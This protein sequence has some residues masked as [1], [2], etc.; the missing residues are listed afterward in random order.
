MIK[1]IE[2]AH[3]FNS[4]MIGM[5]LFDGSMPSEKYLYLRHG[6]NQL[7]YVD[8]KIDFIKDYLIPTT[9]RSAVDKNGFSYRYAYFN[10]DKL[11][12][13]YNKIYID[14]KKRLTDSILNRFDEITL[15]FM[16]MDDGSLVLHKDPKRPGE[17]HSR[18]IYLAVNNFTLHEVT[19]LQRLLKNKWDLNFRISQE[20][21]GYRL[22]C[23][24]ENAI[25]FCSLIAPYVKN[26][27]TMLYKLDFK[28]KKKKLPF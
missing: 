16:Y 13:L 12:H 9:V 17:Y 10:T 2:N 14:G 26:F 25:K 27:P 18:E 28:Y 8:E 20:K 21:S 19:K 7:T 1:K 23:N 3:D 5:I 24:A 6:G 4:A 15:A 22:C 11:K